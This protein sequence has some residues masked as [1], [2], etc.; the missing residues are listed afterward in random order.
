[1]ASWGE[2][3]AGALRELCSLPGG[4]DA[5]VKAGDWRSSANSKR[6]H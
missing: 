5:Q 1:M 4:E 6:K 2:G 3:E